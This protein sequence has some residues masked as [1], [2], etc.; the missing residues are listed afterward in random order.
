MKKILLLAIVLL[1]AVGAFFGYQYYLQQQRVKAISSFEECAEMFSVM[2]SYP[3]QCRTSDGR[4]FVQDIGNELEYHDEISVANPRPN[5]RISSPLQIKG[6]ARGPWYFEASFNAE[7]FDGN[8]KSLGT[9]IL[10]AEGEWMTEEFVPFSGT[11][12]FESTATENGTLKIR[13]A[14]PSGL[15]ENQKELIMP[16]QFK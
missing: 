12:Q 14:N 9:A 13:N 15:P 6:Q 16:V 10:T 11:L 8:N 3:G 1:L 4:H 5:Q 2:T 7:L